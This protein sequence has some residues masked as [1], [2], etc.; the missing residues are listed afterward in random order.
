MEN[1]MTSPL[2]RVTAR[3]A[4]THGDSSIGALLLEA[5]K[6]TPESAERVLRMQKELGIRFGDGGYGNDGVANHGGY[7]GRARSSM[8]CP[9]R[10]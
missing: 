9:V 10:F 4:S 7:G 2:P 6:I 1:T 3:P 8:R 5:G